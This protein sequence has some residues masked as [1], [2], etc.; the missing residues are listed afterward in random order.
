MNFSQESPR[1]PE[2]VKAVLSEIAVV[3]DEVSIFE[4]IAG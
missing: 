2:Q 1:I 4:G 3:Q